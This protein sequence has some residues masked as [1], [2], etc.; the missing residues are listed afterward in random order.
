[1]S[2]HVHTEVNTTTHTTT[3]HF[4]Q[5]YLQ[6]AGLPYTSRVAPNV[7]C[8][9]PSGKTVHV[10]QYF[11]CAHVPTFKDAN[12][13]CSHSNNGSKERLVYTVYVLL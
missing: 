3:S 11:V 1:M 2:I 7:D 4:L 12:C 8:M 6:L 13:N 9:S 5:S 10:L